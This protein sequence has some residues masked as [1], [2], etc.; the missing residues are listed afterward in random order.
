V[1][2]SGVSAQRLS[3]RERNNI[4]ARKSRQRKRCVYML[5]AD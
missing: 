4:S 5:I 3:K 2:S 1:V